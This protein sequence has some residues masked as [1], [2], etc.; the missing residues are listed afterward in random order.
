MVLRL[1]R[2]ILVSFASLLLLVACGGD[3]GPADPTPAPP[4]P[5]P[6]PAPGA[7][8]IVVDPTGV[9]AP[10]RLAGPGGMS[11]EGTGAASLT[12][13]AAG[14][15]A[16]SWLPLEGWDPPT[17]PQET[18][19]LAAGGTV[20]FTGSYRRWTGRIDLE[21]T[22]DT[23]P[24]PW[25][26]SGPEGFSQEGAGAASLG[27]VA[28]GEYTLAWGPLDGWDPPDPAATSLTLAPGGAIGF[29]GE[30]ARWTGT[31]EIRVEGEGVTGPWTL[32]GP[33]GFRRP[34]AGSF[35]F[36]DVPVGEYAVRWGQVDGFVTPVPQRVEGVLGR[37]GT[38][39]FTA[40]WDR[41]VATLTIEVDPEESDGAWWLQGPGGEVESGRGSRTFDGL[42]PAEYTLTWRATQGWELPDPTSVT[43]TIP[44]GGSETVRGT[45][46]APSASLQ[47]SLRPSA[48]PAPWRLTDPF[49]TATMGE[50][51]ASLDRLQS[52]R[53]RMTW[54]DLL[55]WQT[56][57]TVDIE[58][59]E[60]RRVSVLGLYP[61][62]ADPFA[63][64]DSLSR[65]VS[66]GEAALVHPDSGTVVLEAPLARLDDDGR[67]RF[68]G[69]TAERGSFI[70]IRAE[71]LE[72]FGHPLDA[73]DLAIR[74]W[75]QATDGSAS[76]TLLG[77]VNLSPRGL[78]ENHSPIFYAGSDFA[79][80]GS[81][82]A[83]IYG[84]G[85]RTGRQ[86]FRLRV[87]NRGIPP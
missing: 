19:T 51:A 75:R 46:R 14:E 34:G 86:L 68:F 83:E 77:Q 38:L 39:V 7:V 63:S 87:S 43:F 6:P 64:A 35:T 36:E 85:E 60:G 67:S 11:Q 40:R 59:E 28:A 13:V 27:E 61:L 23:L 32:D 42:P 41:A 47:V 82:V 44:A 53:Y 70:A 21:V 50:G 81:W 80:D 8:S 30:Y 54:M 5:P 3:G 79:G 10:W 72:S 9:P 2:P 56:P 31:V 24:A 84:A 29:S 25:V 69:F 55:G 62:M 58:I 16:L 17:P 48:L 76:W 20:S 33:D 65:A 74:L 18:R 12:G 78:P 15:Y 4:P 52:G 73:Q 26:L 57:P 49:G 45:F 1:V 71:P 22:P 66:L 37:N